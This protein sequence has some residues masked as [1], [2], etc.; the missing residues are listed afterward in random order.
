MLRVVAT[1][2]G[3]EPA[4]LPISSR[5]LYGLLVHLAGIGDSVRLG[6]PNR[7]YHSPAEI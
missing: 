4:I 3:L 7:I 5:V 6:E 1:R 2:T